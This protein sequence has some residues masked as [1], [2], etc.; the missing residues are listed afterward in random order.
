MKIKYIKHIQANPHT[1]DVLQLKVV[2]EVRLMT[3]ELCYQ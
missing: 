3:V 1:D 2:Q